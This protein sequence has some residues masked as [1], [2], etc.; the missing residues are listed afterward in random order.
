MN[1]KT[2]E[3]PSRQY[4]T[5]PSL[6]NKP[7]IHHEDGWEKLVE[8]NNI[9]HKLRKSYEREQ[10]YKKINDIKSML[11]GQLLEHKE[12]QRQDKLHKIELQHEIDNQMK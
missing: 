3:T 5:T 9:M 1:A 4:V 12:Q 11:N 8:Y 2:W 6:F 7:S 10:K